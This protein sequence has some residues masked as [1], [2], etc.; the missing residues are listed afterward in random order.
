[1]AEIQSQRN[2]SMQR[3]RQRMGAAFPASGVAGGGTRTGGGTAA[4]A[5][6]AVAR[7]AV[8]EGAEPANR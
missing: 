8:E 3:I 2:E 6:A 4:V 5:L 7:E 1:V